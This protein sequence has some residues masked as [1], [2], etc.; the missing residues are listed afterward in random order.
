M[1]GQAVVW[2][3]LYGQPYTPSAALLTESDS[4]CNI[5]GGVAGEGIMQVAHKV[6]SVVQRQRHECA[7]HQDELHLQA[8]SILLH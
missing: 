7:A 4:F 3:G 1:G 5:A 6:V 8:S 2:S